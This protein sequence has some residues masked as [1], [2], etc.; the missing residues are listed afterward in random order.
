[1]QENI[2]KT[3]LVFKINAFELVAVTSR[4]YGKNTSHRQ[5]MV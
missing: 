4:Y 1:M 2:L 3:F 5:A